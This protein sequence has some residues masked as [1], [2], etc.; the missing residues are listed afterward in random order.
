MYNFVVRS[1]K[2]LCRKRWCLGLD[3]I[4]KWSDTKFI[5][6]L[7][8]AIPNRKMSDPRTLSQRECNN[9]PYWTFH[10]IFMWW[11]HIHYLKLMRIL[12]HPRED[13][14]SSTYWISGFWRWPMSSFQ[15]LMMMIYLPT[16]RFNASSISWRWSQ[17]DGVSSI[18]W[19]GSN[20]HRT[21]FHISPRFP[22]GN[23]STQHSICLSTP[24]LSIL[25]P[26]AL[27]QAQCLPPGRTRRFTLVFMEVFLVHNIHS[28]L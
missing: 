2:I 18:R 16:N 14:K 10:H 19:A 22:C 8:P 11:K 15:S 7:I 28:C 17:V 23:A 26:F 13:R 6:F 25:L 5:R 9:L 12:I 4:K 20:V 21:Q 1:N 27:H 3:L 24:S